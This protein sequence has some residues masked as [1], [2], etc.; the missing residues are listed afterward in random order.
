[1]YKFTSLVFVFQL[2]ASTNETSELEVLL[3][4][5]VQAQGIST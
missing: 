4:E 5:K 1:M 2:E 3:R